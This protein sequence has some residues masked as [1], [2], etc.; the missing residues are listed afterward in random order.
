[1][2]AFEH[3]ARAFKRGKHL[4]ANP[5][6]FGTTEWREWRTG[7]IY[8]NQTPAWTSYDYNTAR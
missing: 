5:F 3:G 8:G 4:Q 2:T 1:M 6:D 7:Y